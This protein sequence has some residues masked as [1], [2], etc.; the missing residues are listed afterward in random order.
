MTD[1]PT[2]EAPASQFLLPEGFDPTQTPGFAETKASVAADGQL[3]DVLACESETQ[4]GKLDVVDGLHRVHI[5]GSLA[6]MVRYQL[7]PKPRNRAERLALIHKVNSKRRVVRA[8]EQRATLVGIMEDRRCTA[9]EAARLM[10]ISEGRASQLR[11][12]RRIPR[13]LME[14]LDVAKACDAVILMIGPLDS[15]DT[16]AKAVTFATT[17][18]ENSLPSRD[19]VAA[20]IGKLEKVAET[21][22]AKP[23]TLRGKVDGIPF[24]LGFQKGQTTASLIEALKK[25]IKQLTDHDNLPPSSLGPLFA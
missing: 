24:T 16:M 20:F 4:P 7:V 25:L 1:N 18:V 22:G 21:R 5:L 9:A 11:A 15:H 17:P 2:R 6:K 8:A 14:R 23:R 12:M 10:G 13:E 3:V 19:A